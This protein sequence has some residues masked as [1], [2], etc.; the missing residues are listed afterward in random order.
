MHGHT[1]GHTGSKAIA[2]AKTPYGTF[3]LCAACVNAGHAGLNRAPHRF[4]RLQLVGS[5]AEQ[6][7]CDC[8]HVSHVPAPK[9]DAAE[10]AGV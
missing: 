6:P 2:R 1:Y 9:S 4:E 8:E 5:Y 7:V 3:H 10:S